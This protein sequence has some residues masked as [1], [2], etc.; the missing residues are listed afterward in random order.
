MYQKKRIFLNI[1]II[2]L[3]FLSSGIQLFSQVNAGKDTSICL[4]SHTIFAIPT[5]GYWITNSSATIVSPSN[6]TTGVTGLDQGPN[7]FIYV[8]SGLGRDTLVVTN[9]QV[10]ADAGS[11][12]DPSCLSDADLSGNSIPVGGNGTWALK[13]STPGIIIDNTA[14]NNTQA[15]KLPFGNTIFTWTITANGCSSTDEVSFNNNTPE[16]NDGTDQSACSNIFY[17]DAETPPTG[18][19][20]IWSQIFSPGSVSFDNAT[21]HGVQITAPIGQ[22][23][24]RWTINYMSCSS[25]KDFII[26]NNLTN[27]DAGNNQQICSNSVSLSAQ[28]PLVTE[29]GYW[30]IIDQQSE[31]ISNASIHNPSVTNL[32]QGTTTFV[33]HLNNDNKPHKRLHC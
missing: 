15:H 20:G 32:K 14:S 6:Q 9:N 30:T 10:T 16:N 29:N 5:G 28:P 4:N 27:P 22:S 24:V 8:V 26:E 1:I 33:W 19:S 2:L 25:F 31:I 12:R 11:D 3:L 17:I 7:E 21:S 13:Y 23:T 18:G